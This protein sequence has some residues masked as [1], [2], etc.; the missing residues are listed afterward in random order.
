[1]GKKENETPKSFRLSISLAALG[2]LDEITDFI[3]YVNRQLLNA[4]KVGDVIFDTIEKIRKNPFAYKECEA[5]RTKTK[6]YRQAVCMSWLIIYKIMKSEFVFLEL[7]M[8]PG[9]LRWLRNLE[10]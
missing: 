4:V 10:K 7:F 9:N 3:A 1:M 8:V 6:I 5:I 2:D